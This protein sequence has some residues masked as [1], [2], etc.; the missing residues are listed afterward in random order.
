[1][2][3]YLAL[4]GKGPSRCAAK[5]ATDVG[6]TLKGD[7]ELD[8]R[9]PED[10]RTRVLNAFVHYCDDQAAE[11]PP[12]T[13]VAHGTQQKKHAHAVS[14]FPAGAAPFNHR[15]VAS[16]AGGSP[17]DD[18][19]RTSQK[20]GT[21]RERTPPGEQM[22]GMQVDAPMQNAAALFPEAG[23]QDMSDGGSSIVTPS[24]GRKREREA[25]AEADRRT[26]EHGSMHAH[27]QQQRVQASEVTGLA[28]SASGSI[29]G[30]SA[31][32]NSADG[33]GGAGAGT[34]LRLGS[35]GGHSSGS[36]PPSQHKRSRS[37]GDA[38]LPVTALASLLDDDDEGEGE[39]AQ[40]PF[41][42]HMH[43]SMATRNRVALASAQEQGAVNHAEAG[44]PSHSHRYLSHARGHRRAASG[45]SS[46]ISSLGDLAVSSITSVTS[47]SSLASY[48]IDPAAE[49]ERT[50]SYGNER[51]H[52]HEHGQCPHAQ[53]HTFGDATDAQAAGDGS[54]AD[55]TD[56]SAN[57]WAA[58][59]SFS[60]E[61]GLD[62]RKP[63]T[64][65]PPAAPDRNPLR[66]PDSRPQHQGEPV[67]QNDI[68]LSL[69][70]EAYA[71]GL[72]TS[73]PASSN[74][75]SETS[76]SSKS[77]SASSSAADADNTTPAGSSSNDGS[78]G[79]STGSGINSTSNSGLN[80]KTTIGD[81]RTAPATE[82]TA[83]RDSSTAASTS[84]QSLSI[85]TSRHSPFPST[86][87]MSL[88]QSAHPSHLSKAA[89]PAAAEVCGT[90]ATGSCGLLTNAN[91]SNTSH[92][93]ATGS[94]PTIAPKTSASGRDC[95]YCQGMG[96][97]A[98]VLLYV[99]PE[100]EA[101]AALVQLVLHGVPGLYDARQ[102]GV[103][104][105]CALADAILL[106]SDPQVHAHFLAIYGPFSSHAELMF[107]S[108]IASLYAHR[109]PL[110]TIVQLWDVVLAAGS[111][112]VPLL[113]AAEVGLRRDELLGAGRNAITRFQGIGRG[114]ASTTH[115][116]SSSAGGASTGTVASTAKPPAVAGAGALGGAWL[117]PA[118][119]L[120]AV[121][122]DMLHRLP[123]PLYGRLQDFARKISP[124]AHG[125]SSCSG[126]NGQAGDG[127]AAG[128]GSPVHWRKPSTA[129]SPPV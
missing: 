67:D 108:R 120:L 30:G 51:D 58:P 102:R 114:T 106:A 45:A 111:H 6:R 112:M 19:D 90:C 117:P 33:S 20:K 109:P 129:A 25:G 11:A 28:G 80:E 92:P 94:P 18:S 39:R 1:M 5:I 76:A 124:Y 43:A 52:D 60:P 13:T 40:G 24:K 47:G 38:E 96:S 63:A 14:S 98:A 3:R 15:P 95:G 35:S 91:T 62:N 127:A 121:A 101:F 4:V 42:N 29:G 69:R 110:A 73:T 116:S 103:R 99:L 66:E 48:G 53:E 75:N 34:A 122:Y 107:F 78:T 70:E 119:D 97:L 86:L 49:N 88:L 32:T 8:R 37:S 79:G 23:D 59:A 123:E 64:S 61:A 87:P 21:V 100:P 54:A 71:S 36:S 22:P 105:G 16:A 46:S 72:S 126:S 56:N 12:T 113:C 9:A 44:W 115:A 84:Q 65:V 125:G 81:N 85:D 10:A 41:Q 74:S 2:D 50:G 118:E 26:S 27:P 93:T 55:A 31:G 104:E 57:S 17:G 68:E 77:T 89:A 128:S 83:T 7:P 82:D